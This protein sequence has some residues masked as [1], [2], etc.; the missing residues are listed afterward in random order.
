MGEFDSAIEDYNTAIELDPN[1]AEAYYNR[2]LVYLVE[3]ELEL[4]IDD[5]DKAFESNPNYA[6]AYYNRGVVWSR[7]EKWENARLDLT[8]ANIIGK[9]SINVFRPINRNIVN[10]ERSPDVNP[11]EDIAAML[12]PP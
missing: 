11:P 2:G 1:L 10:L 5:M 9:Y 4:A 8:V 3:G 12:T 6:E 7:L